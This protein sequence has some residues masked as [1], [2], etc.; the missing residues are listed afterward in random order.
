MVML[1]HVL[2]VDRKAMRDI[3]SEHRRSWN[4]VLVVSGSVTFSVVIQ[5]ISNTGN[6]GLV[7]LAKYETAC[8]SLM[9]SLSKEIRYLTTSA[10]TRCPFSVISNF[11]VFLERPLGGPQTWQVA[12]GFLYSS[13]LWFLRLLF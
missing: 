2:I 1:F 11:L 3:L 9:S 4:R 13:F 10:G 12:E 5:T 6:I 8:S 7:G